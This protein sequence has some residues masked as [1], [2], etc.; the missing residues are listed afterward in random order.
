MSWYRELLGGE[1]VEFA[2]E[3]SVMRWEVTGGN[4]VGL[5]VHEGVEVGFVIPCRRSDLNE[6]MLGPT[7]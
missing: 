2:K 1:G 5:E 4:E 3:V 6:S 7:S